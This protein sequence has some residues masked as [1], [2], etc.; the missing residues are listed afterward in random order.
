MDV[1]SSF[2]QD[3][4]ILGNQVRS[5]LR[6]AEDGIRSWKDQISPQQKGAGNSTIGLSKVT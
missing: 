2:W 3:E 5:L 6:R 1:L 4:V